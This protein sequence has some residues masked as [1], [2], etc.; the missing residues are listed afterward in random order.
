MWRRARGAGEVGRMG[1]SGVLM[2]GRGKVWV[3]AGVDGEVLV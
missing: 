1:K 2:I 3:L